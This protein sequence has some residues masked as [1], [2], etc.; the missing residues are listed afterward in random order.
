MSFLSSL[1][2]ASTLGT[3]CC[4]AFLYLV[5]IKKQRTNLPPSPKGLPLIGHLHLMYVELVASSLDIAL[6]PIRRPPKRPWIWFDKLAQQ[7]DSPLVYL[8][9]AGQDMVIVNDYAAGVELV[10]SCGIFYA[11]VHQS[12]AWCSW[13]NVQRITPRA[14]G[15]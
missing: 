1:L 5:F 11:S 6:I 14:H 3:F 15:S 4:F 2:P 8:N 9:L 13:K 7:F 12:L 10:S